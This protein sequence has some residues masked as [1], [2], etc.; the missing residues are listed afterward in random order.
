MA[1]EMGISLKQI[2]HRM[3]TLPCRFLRLE[4]PVLAPGADASLVLFDWETVRERNDYLDPLLPPHGID[5]VWVHG[6]LVLDHGEFHPPS[7]FPG[8]ILMSSPRH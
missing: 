4:S 7:Q 6:H 5:A 3:S 2:V 8:R 1:R